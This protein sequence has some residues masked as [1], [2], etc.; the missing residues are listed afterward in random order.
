MMMMATTTIMTMMINFF[1]V[2]FQAIQRAV[3]IMWSNTSA[4]IVTYIHGGNNTQP[5]NKIHIYIYIQ[6][7]QKVPAAQVIYMSLGINKSLDL[8]YYC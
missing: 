2:Q 3:Q 8:I 6:K 7:N 5:T 4:K 1:K